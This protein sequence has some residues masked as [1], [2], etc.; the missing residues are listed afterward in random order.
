MILELQCTS[1]CTRRRCLE[2]VAYRHTINSFTRWTRCVQ[3]RR[4]SK[5]D[6]H[7]REVAG[8]VNLPGG[9]TESER[10]KNTVASALLNV[11]ARFGSSRLGYATLFLHACAWF[12]FCLRF[13]VRSCFAVCFAICFAVCFA[14]A[15]ALFYGCALLQFGFFFV[16]ALAFAS[17]FLL[18][19]LCYCCCFAVVFALAFALE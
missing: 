2:P 18:P 15:L 7:Q 11:R 14:F 19:L 9:K 17:A 3:W 16:L 5:P 10:A 13:C 12:G 6:A 4:I 1:T 8:C